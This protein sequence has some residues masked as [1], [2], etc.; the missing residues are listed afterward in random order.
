MKKIAILAQKGGV[1]KTTLCLNL[2]IAAKLD[3]KK[4]AV[5]DMDPQ[6]S[7]SEWAKTRTQ[8]WPQIRATSISVLPKMLSVLNDLKTHFVFIDTLPKDDDLTATAAAKEADII[9]IPVGKSILDVRGIA[10]TVTIAQA[11]NKP[12]FFVLNRFPYGPARKEKVIKVL[13]SKYPNI[14]IAP[15]SLIE[16]PTY[17]ASLEHGLGVIEFKPKSHA[18]S[19]MKALYKYLLKQIKECQS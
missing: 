1:G 15:I 17:D 18:A 11:T 8:Q 3:R 4:S 6:K 14:P 10:P 9:I 19:D 2:A 13:K 16:R 12:T 5:I 7:S